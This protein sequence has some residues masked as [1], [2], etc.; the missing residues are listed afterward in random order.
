ME[1]EES[2]AVMLQMRVVLPRRTTVLEEVVER[3]VW[4]RVSWRD[5]RRERPEGRML[6]SR[7]RRRKSRGRSFLNILYYLVYRLWGGVYDAGKVD[8][9]IAPEESVVMMGNVFCF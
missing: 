8:I 6:R 4:E 3:V 9:G 7:W 5:S 1:G 2:W